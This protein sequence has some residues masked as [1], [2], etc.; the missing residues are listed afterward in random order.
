MNILYWWLVRSHA[1]EPTLRVQLFCISTSIQ[2]EVKHLSIVLT[3]FSGQWCAGFGY[4]H[5]STFSVQINDSIDRQGDASGCWSLVN[6]VNVEVEDSIRCAHDADLQIC[7]TQPSTSWN[8]VFECSIGIQH[9]ILVG[10]KHD[11]DP[12]YVLHNHQDT[13]LQC[14]TK[15]SRYQPA[16]C[17]K[18]ASTSWNTTK[19]SVWHQGLFPYLSHYGHMMFVIIFYRTIGTRCVVWST[20]CQPPL[21]SHSIFHA[22]NLSWV[23]QADQVNFIFLALLL[24][25]WPSRDTYQLM[26]VLA[27]SPIRAPNK[28]CDC[29]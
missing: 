29:L 22:P 17:F 16:I 19:K 6:P 12:Q 18:K 26:V 20:L 21:L 7:F 11:A 24:Y 28:A 2:Q 8:R 5:L 1:F 4:G 13:D 3:I 14:F 23:G 9:R 15:S 10:I 25:P 27:N